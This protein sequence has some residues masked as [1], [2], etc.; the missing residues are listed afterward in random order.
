[1][2]NLEQSV[3]ESRLV[4][5]RIIEALQQLMVPFAY[6]SLREDFVSSF[7]YL[8]TSKCSINYSQVRFLFY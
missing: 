1:M 6:L 4:M 7:Y 5:K 3:T 2:V 8:L